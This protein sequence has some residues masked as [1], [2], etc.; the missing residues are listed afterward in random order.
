MAPAMAPA[1]M[2]PLL[3]AAVRYANDTNYCQSA[4]CDDN[5]KGYYCK[6]HKTCRWGFFFSGI[7]RLVGELNDGRNTCEQ[8]TTRPP[9]SY[10]R[11]CRE[12]LQIVDCSRK[13]EAPFHAGQSI[14][15]NRRILVCIQ[16][17]IPL[18]QFLIE[19]VH[20]LYQI[21]PES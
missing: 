3:W 4:T 14:P 8:S 1:D 9:L 6:S 19:S 21:N 10:G 18:Y 12:G 13:Y 11:G 15:H 20:G 5:S 17:S 2:M 16:I 7:L